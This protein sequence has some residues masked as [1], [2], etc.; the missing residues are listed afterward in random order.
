MGVGTF[1]LYISI[2]ICGVIFTRSCQDGNTFYR[3]TFLPA[4]ACELYWGTIQVTLHNHIYMCTCIVNQTRDK[5]GFC[6]F[7]FT[8]SH[9][10]IVTVSVM[11]FMTLYS[12][13][14]KAV[15]PGLFRVPTLPAKIQSPCHSKSIY[16]LPF[17]ACL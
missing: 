2:L 5:P 4:F 3:C 11:F 7:L 16:T 9:A 8:T 6:L 10:A 12:V 15:V 13:L 14:P 1:Q 17:L